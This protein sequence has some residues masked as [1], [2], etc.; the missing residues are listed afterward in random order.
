MILCVSNGP[1]RDVCR[2]L[3][4]FGVGLIGRP[5]IQEYRR[6]SFSSVQKFPF[7]WEDIETRSK[8]EVDILAWIS[9]SLK[10]ASVGRLDIV[11]AAG[12]VGFS[13][14]SK[15]ANDEL[16]AFHDVISMVS[17]IQQILNP[18]SACFHMVSSA[19]A[20]FEGQ[21]FVG[22]SS[23]PNPRSE[24]GHLKFEQE[25][26]LRSRLRDSFFIRIYRPSTVY[27]LVLEKNRRG[28]I[29]VLLACAHNG[30]FAELYGGVGVIRDYV[31][32]DDVARFIVSNIMAGSV[33]SDS[34]MLVSGKPTSMYEVIQAVQE[35]TGKAL[36]I[37]IHHAQHNDSN[38]SYQTSIFPK[39]WRPTG[40]RIGLQTTYS[41]AKEHL[42]VTHR[43]S[44]H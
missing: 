24:Y 44:M 7:D 41:Q 32:S 2:L 4:V 23:C 1:Q 30:Q 28:L 15:A 40:F 25:R 21:R 12:K 31:L 43:E 26:I 11:W 27:G 5:I 9:A 18:E 39:N 35:V 42:W 22:R 34:S 13:C 19:G 6:K 10:K 8:H 29:A 33:I 17:R 3:L 37:G 14:T 16:T 38:N 20:L 36:Y